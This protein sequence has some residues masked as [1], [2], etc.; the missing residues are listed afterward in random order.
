MLQ[1]DLRGNPPGADLLQVLHEVFESL[2]AQV[3]M[4]FIQCYGFE[5]HIPFYQRPRTPETSNNDDD[6]DMAGINHHEAMLPGVVSRTI[7]FISSQ[8]S[9]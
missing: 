9:F 3:K 4:G 1:I 7:V 2:E 8:G 5:L 6:D